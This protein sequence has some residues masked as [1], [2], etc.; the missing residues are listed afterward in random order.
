MLINLI[1]KKI[2]LTN[3]IKEDIDQIIE[4][5]K[6]NNNFVNH[7]EKDH[8]IK[9]LD[10]KDCF[11]LSIRRVDNDKLVGHMILF[12]G[13]SKDSVLEFRR[14][15]INE[16]GA[17]YGREAVQLLKKLAFEVLS[18]HRLWLDVYSDNARAIH[19][20]ESEGFILEGELRD[21]FKTENGY[22]SQKIYS[23]LEGEYRSRS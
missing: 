18:Y 2:R 20:Y 1:G 15:A 11:H 6:L 4:F 19:V 22:R 21:K 3:T 16:K 7:Y 5:E 14:L 12:G 10:D 8:H 17:G 13:E 23:M 9:L